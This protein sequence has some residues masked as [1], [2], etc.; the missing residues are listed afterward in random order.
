MTRKKQLFR[1]IENLKA[2]KSEYKTKTIFFLSLTKIKHSSTKNVTKSVIFPPRAENF[3][4]TCICRLCENF[5]F[6]I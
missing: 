6:D 2:R 4:S 3:V 5:E 1:I